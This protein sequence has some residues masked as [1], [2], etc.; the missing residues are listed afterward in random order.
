MMKPYY[1]HAGITIYHGDC[2]EILPHVKADVLVTDPPYGIGYRTSSSRSVLCRSRDYPPVTGDDE[3]FDPSH[4]PLSKPSIVWGGNNF[5]SRLP[6]SPAWLVWDKRREG[7]S[8]DSADVEL[9]WSN[10]HTP[11]RRYVCEWMGMLRDA[12]RGLSVHP[13]QKPVPL[14]AW[15][16]SLCPAGV[17]LDPYCGS[18]PTLRAAKNVGRRAIGIEIEE[19]Y[20]EV[21][22]R[23]CEQ[24]VLG[25]T[26]GA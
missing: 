14:M 13:T 22:A 12:E 8:N 10:L 4:L 7:V 16:L 17:V 11:A 6:D 26:V 23:R 19:R 24:E 9:A 5:A 15:C 2:R 3:P 25:L 20:C 1:E 21:A 18:G